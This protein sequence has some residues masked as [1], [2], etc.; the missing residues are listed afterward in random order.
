VAEPTRISSVL[1][2]PREGVARHDFRGGN[3][4]ML[5]MLNRYRV[6][7]GVEALPQELDAAARATIDHLATESATVAIDGASLAGG[8]LA[9]EVTAGNL[10]GHKLPTAYPSRRSWLHVTVR[11]RAG[12]LV[13]ESGGITP[14]GLIRGNDND[15]DPARVEP[16]HREI[17][18][19]SAVQIYE[20]VMGDAAGAPTTGLLKGT[21]YLK[22]NRLLPRGFDKAT[23]DGDIAVHGGARDDADFSG[24]GDRVRYALDVEPASGPF[25]VDA[26][27]CYQP[28]GFRW[29]ENLSAYDAP[30]PRRFTAYYRSMSAAS[31]AVLARSRTTVR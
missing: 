19:A 29:A 3:F 4:F 6:E 14:A 2:E 10:A 30:E 31:M 8:R 13:F 25:Q 23:A 24:G 12:A 18:S 11:D 21:R 15:E 9:F 28:I 5:R 17:R 22:D 1:G 27:L 16:H 20:S 7:L 26:E